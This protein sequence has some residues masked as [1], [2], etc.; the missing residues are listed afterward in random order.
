MKRIIT[1]FLVLMTG[2]VSTISAQ[3]DMTDKIYNPDFEFDRHTEGWQV[4]GF[5]PH[6]GGFSYGHGQWFLE[7]WTGAG[8]R[9]GDSYCEQTVT[10]LPPGTYTVTVAA[11]NIQQGSNDAP[12]TGAFLYVQDQQVEFGAANNYKLTSTIHDGNLTFGIKLVNCTG[13]W[14]CF[15]NFRLTYTEVPENLRPYIQIY[16]DE[17][18]NIDQH[19]SSPERTELIAAR[20]NLLRYKSELDEGIAAAMIRLMDAIKAYRYSIASVSNPY[21]MTDHISDPS[22]E[23]TCQGW[24]FDGMSTQSNDGYRDLKDGH[25][26]V[27]RWT[28]SGGAG[29]GSV[30]QEVTELPSGNYRLVARA[31]NMTQSSESYSGNTGAYIVADDEKTEVKLLNDY[32]VTFFVLGGTADI[33]FRAINAT[34]NW[35]AVDNFRLYYLGPDASKASTVLANR[36]SYAQTLLD[37]HMD[38]SVKTELQQAIQQAQAANTLELIDA[39]AAQLKPAVKAAEASIAAYQELYDAVTSAETTFNQSSGTEGRDAMQEVINEAWGLYNGMT[40]TTEQMKDVEKRLTDNLFA[41]LVANGTGTAPTVTSNEVIVYGCKAAVGRMDAKGGTIIERGFCWSTE[42]EPTVLDNRSKTI[43]EFNGKIY[44]MENMLPATQ[45]FVRAYAITKDYAVGYGPQTRI[46]TLPEAD[47][48]YSYNWAAPDDETNERIN[49]ACATA[50]YYLNTWTSIRGYRPSVNYDAGEDGAHGGYGGW[51]TLGP[52]F[53]QNPGTVMHEMGHGIGVGQHW[54]Y[55]SWDSPLHPTYLW[56]GERANRVFAFFENQPDQP[57]NPDGSFPSGGN[58]TIADGDRVH[59]CYGLS[60]VTAPIDLLRQAAFYQGMYE[61]GMPAVGDGACPFYSFE[62]YDNVKY[63]LTNEKYNYGVKF[64][65]EANSK[66]SYKKVSMLEAKADDAYAWNVIYEPTTGLYFLRNVASGNYI[67]YNGSAFVTRSTANPSQSER[68]QL[69]PV[70][71]TS[72]TKVG[73]EKLTQKTYW[74]VRGNRVETPETM[75]ISSSA[76]A[77]VTAPTL[78]FW[79]NSQDQHWAILSADDLDGIEQVYIDFNGRRLQELIDGSRKLLATPHENIDPEETN[80]DADFQTLVDE[81]D[82]SRATMTTSADYSNAVKTFSTDISTYLSKIQPASISQP[83]DLTFLIDDPTFIDGSSWTG[84]DDPQRAVGAPLEFNNSAFEFSQVLS[85]TPRGTYM[86]VVEGFQSP[87]K[88]STACTDYK[89]GT[90][91]VTATA[92]V[93]YGSNKISHKLPHI[94]EGGQEE[95]FNEGGTELKSQ[96]LNVP[97][98]TAAAKVYINHGCYETSF[99][100]KNTVKTMTITLQDKTATENFWTALGDVKLYY[101]GTEITKEQVTGIE[102]IQ[103]EQNGE[104][105]SEVQAYYNVSG[106]QIAKPLENGITIIKFKDGH[107]RKIIR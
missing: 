7:R 63:Y 95:K 93:T 15:D 25:R 32:S 77:S 66:L 35:L 91:N 69:M 75:T 16:V 40:A 102:D 46:I 73:G 52:G 17:A 27:E 84:L 31:Y 62:S 8:G 9:L 86:L 28:G 10:K 48:V 3:T 41:Y 89:K 12:S 72:E 81:T 20:D 99:I 23:I 56:E 21:D 82:A 78:N 39:A 64:L 5:G 68:I 49:N 29:S 88:V 71:Y 53:T 107:S 90:N 74:M 11:Q 76:T 19:N 100:F 34:G 97:F 101:Y 36:V 57:R 105:S 43:Y 98:N 6:S 103:I 47:V 60:G 61:D 37:K 96:G 33:G 58:H 87:G 104:F 30:I 26:Y 18:N 14:A 54:R 80:L 24:V 65:T 55:T 79:D 1:L 22:F 13:N 70:R 94:Y 38:A 67:T 92:T 50:T 59:V 106:V 42:P 51:I 45:Y 85:G 2:F 83:L 4:S 44:L